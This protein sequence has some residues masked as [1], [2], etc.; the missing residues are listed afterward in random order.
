MQIVVTL[1]YYL[2]SWLKNVHV[3]RIYLFIFIYNFAYP[4]DYLSIH[5]L[6]PS[7]FKK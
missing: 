5:I 6:L 7:S 1:M 2:Q 3:H 4:L